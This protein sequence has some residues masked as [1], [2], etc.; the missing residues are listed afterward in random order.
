M[1]VKAL[2]EKGHETRYVYIQ[3]VRRYSWSIRS[4]FATEASDSNSFIKHKRE[5]LFALGAIHAAKFCLK[6]ARFLTWKM[7]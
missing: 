4:L 1:D 7:P 3:Y 5:I 6:T 2:P